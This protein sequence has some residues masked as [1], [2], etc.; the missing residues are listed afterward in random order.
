MVNIRQTFGAPDG[1]LHSEELHDMYS[2]HN[3][4]REFKSRGMRYA[5]HVAHMGETSS[6]YKTSVG[7]PERKIPLWRSKGKFEDNIKIDVK[8]I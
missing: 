3:V 7:K 4:I 1:K 2:S 5:G 6:S 8:E